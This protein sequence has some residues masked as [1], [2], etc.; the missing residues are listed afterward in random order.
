[1]S[2]AQCQCLTIKKTQC[3]NN[4]K[5]GTKFCHLHQECQHLLPTFAAATSATSPAVVKT[6]I[7]ENK[8]D[9]ANKVDKADKMDKEDKE[10]KEDK[11]EQK[12]KNKTNIVIGKGLWTDK[13]L[14]ENMNEL[15]GPSECYPLWLDDDSKDKFTKFKL[16]FLAGVLDPNVTVNDPDKR[17]CDLINQFGPSETWLNQQQ[18]Y[19][20][21]LTKVE[22][23]G[24]FSYSSKGDA[25]INEYIRK[26]NQ[27]DTVSLDNIL[28][29]LIKKMQDNYQFV[30]DQ[31]M[32]EAL[33]ENDVTPENHLF[34][35]GM[36]KGT[37]VVAKNINLGYFTK[38]AGHRAIKHVINRLTNIILDA[39]PL[40]KDI[41]V[42]RGVL[43]TDYL[44]MG[45]TV[46]ISGFFST[47]FNYKV[48]LEFALNAERQRSDRQGSVLAILVPA[49]TRGLAA[50]VGTT[51]F[52]SE[53]EFLLPPNINLIL[54]ECT[55][56][57]PVAY[58]STINYSNIDRPVLKHS[59]SFG[60]VKITFCT[61]TLVP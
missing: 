49:G 23:D 10:D 41:V 45:S 56:D 16:R 55:R 59:C 35:M 39:P 9:K 58:L 21:G 29:Y 53:A 37:P 48:A 15:L 4:V 42:Y 34:S 1:M 20:K 12:K 22:K 2:K 57:V 46:P 28:G 25:L 47:S 26:S 5:A 14:C 60:D 7:K 27:N 19:I 54:E 13:T 32:A 31:L 38:E 61:A 8:T 30:F 33:S 50:G 51:K 3:K 6:Q 36:Y 17:L 24:L 43:N 52:V 40:D 44:K 11:G 18:K